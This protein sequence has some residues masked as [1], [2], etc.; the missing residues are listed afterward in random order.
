VIRSMT[1]FGT[2][3]AE[4]PGGRMSVEVRSVN[5]RFSEVQI[6]LPRDLAVLE[7][8]ARAM[9]QERVRRGRVEVIV[10]RDEGTRRARTVRVDAELAAAYT[11]AL[12]ELGT[13]VGV[14][15]EVSLQQVAALPDVLRVEDERTDAE[16]VWPAL[17]GAIR[18]AADALVAMR[19][20]EGGRLAEDL[21]RRAASVDALAEAVA[22][23]SRDV[24]RGYRERLRVRLTEALAEIPVD[25]ARVAAELALFA[26]RSDIT[27][28][29]TRLRSHLVQF[30]QTVV[31][32]DGAV[33]RKLDF[34]LQ[35][36]GRETN[37]IGSKANDLEI[38]RTIIGMKSELESLREQVQNVE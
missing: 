32:E 36:M 4:V 15:G 28:E 38:T 13:A 19:E 3:T 1:G 31:E 35:E 7:D 24:V 10:T 37:T 17:E 23:R 33:G 18:R 9:V 30:R 6:R 14:P 11:R 22:A 27:E 29:L 34:I 12:H 20:A 25:E 5:H 8:R 21:L 26:D 2:A 16:A